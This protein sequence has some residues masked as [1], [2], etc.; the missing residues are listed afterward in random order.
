MKPL[1]AA[2]AILVFSAAVFGQA[3]LK[4]K[5]LSAL[6]GEKWIGQLTYLDYRSN[7]P[8][9]IKSNLTV[10]KTGDSAWS[11]AYQYPDEPKANSTGEVTLSADGKSFNNQAVVSKRK[12]SGGGIEIVTNKEGDDNNKKALFRFTYTITPKTFSIRKEVQVEG[13]TEWFERNTYSWSRP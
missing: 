9:T 8:T 5:D 1:T 10:T 13:S 12:N 2:A 4:P 11:F 7:K 6:T 3:T